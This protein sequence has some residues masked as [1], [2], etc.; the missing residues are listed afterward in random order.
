MTTSG[1][2]HLRS[3]FF[4]R[5]RFIR[6]LT[7]PAGSAFAMALLVTSFLL[8]DPPQIVDEFSGKVVS[9]ADGDT[10]TVLVDEVQIK[11]RLEGIDAPESGQSFGT[12][13][14]QALSQLVFGKVVTV[15]KTGSDRY[16]RTLGIVNVGNLDANAMM[17]EDGWAWHYK[18]YNKDPRLASLEIAARDAKRGLWED[19]SPL[20]P[21]EFRARKRFAK[22]VD[23]PSDGV[24]RM[25]WLNASSGV[26]HNSTCEHFGNTSQ[27][28]KCGP[29][30]GRPCGKCGG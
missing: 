18:Q 14:K 23:E 16:G 15:K 5:I 10:V 22:S 6:S 8:A 2:P 25:Y 27:G 3:Q 29:N 17:I 13:S 9:V 26:R 24:P 21:W 20:A 12:R 19:P 11:V 28:R 7:K 4:W 30:E 1:K